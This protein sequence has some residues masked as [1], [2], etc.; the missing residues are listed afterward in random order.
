MRAGPGRGARRWSASDAC[1][2]GAGR[3]QP[4][5]H[6]GEGAVAA[7]ACRRVRL[8]SQVRG[9]PH[10]SLPAHPRYPTPPPPPPAPPRPPCPM[11]ASSVN[12]HTHTH[13]VV[14]RGAVLRRAAWP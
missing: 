7:G 11:V 3:D 6:S 1:A 5:G 4:C 13:Q 9:S 8:A 12:T 2:H 14:H 10:P